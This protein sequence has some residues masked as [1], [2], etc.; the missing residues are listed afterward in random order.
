MLRK[1]SDSGF[2]HLFL[3]LAVIVIVA[4]G[5][6]GWRV[7]SKAKD[8]SNN[9]TSKILTSNASADDKAIKAGRMLSNNNCSG[10]G[11]TTFTHLPMN[12]DDFSLLIPY[13]LTVG[14]HVTPIDHQYFQPTVFQSAKDTYPVY[15]MADAKI[16][17]VEVHP[18]ENG[19]LGRI[20]LV[21]SV[22]CTFF[23]YYDLV[24]SVQPGIDKDHLPISVKAGQ[25]IGH[26]GGQTLDFAVWN[27][28][29]PLSGFVNP[30]SYDGEAWKIYTADPFPYY[31]PALRQIVESKDSRTAEPIAGK[32]DYDIDGKLIG[33][34]FEKSTGGY[35]GNSTSHDPNYFKTHL[36]FAP[37]LYDPSYFRVSIG[38]LY[39]QVQNQSDMQHVTLTN[40]PDPKDVDVSR[41]LVK[42]DLVGWDYIKNGGSS[43]DQ[44]AVAKEVKLK[45]KSN[46][47]GCGIVQMTAARE[48]KF[49]VFVGKQCSSISSFDSAAKTYTR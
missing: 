17:D 32:I 36:S 1:N 19:S 4:I 11:E 8:K 35:G 42:Y 3:F 28:K 20:R 31:T 49:E 25:L 43:W 47:F 15:A 14:G 7:F 2:G 37:D 10:S 41:G 13:G 27:T 44:M 26:I 33:N 46:V 22:S 30:V 12:A 48:L 21:F 24:T 6:A 40:S 9:S 39:N 23:Y 45:P 18:P 34:W 29:K 16:T 5:F 38:S